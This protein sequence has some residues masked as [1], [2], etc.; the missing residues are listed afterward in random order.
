MPV[1]LFVKFFLYSLWSDACYK[2]RRIIVN[3]SHIQSIYKIV[4]VNVGCNISLIKKL[5]VIIDQ[6]EISSVNDTVL[7]YIAA[8]KTPLSAFVF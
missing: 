2:I 8:V 6:T 7:I 1:F 5:N 4:T 3:I